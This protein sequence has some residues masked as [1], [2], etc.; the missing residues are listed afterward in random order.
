M[1]NDEATLDLNQ[2][3]SCVNALK[4]SIRDE[5]QKAQREIF[6]SFMGEVLKIDSADEVF[7][8]ME[9]NYIEELN[10]LADDDIPLSKRVLAFV[11]SPFL[12]DLLTYKNLRYEREIKSFLKNVQ[13][14]LKQTSQES[15]DN[16]V[17]FIHAFLERGLNDV[18]L[19]LT[20]ENLTDNIPQD[21][22]STL[23]KPIDTWFKGS[24][25]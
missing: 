6:R 2:F 3:L 16:D 1:D 17:K 20:K 21:I 19:G 12:Y 24:N 4:D 22:L 10:A 23:I 5:Q 18:V 25:M 15:S 14:L 7:A 9:S 8:E 11:E 13:V